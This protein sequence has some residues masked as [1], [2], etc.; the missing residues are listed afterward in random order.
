MLTS[1]IGAGTL[2][3]AVRE[4]DERGLP[5]SQHLCN[6]RV[7]KNQANFSTRFFRYNVHVEER[8]YILQLCV[9]YTYLQYWL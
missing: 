1:V 8:K 9:R 6:S 3:R 4:R 5:L 7:L 2:Y